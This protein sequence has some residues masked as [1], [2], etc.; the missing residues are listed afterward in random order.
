[1]PDHPVPLRTWKIQDLLM[2]SGIEVEAIIPSHP[3]GKPTR[4]KKSIDVENERET[5]IGGRAIG[6]YDRSAH[7]LW[8]LDKQQGRANRK[9]VYQPVTPFFAVAFLMALACHGSL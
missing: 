7:L 9:H 4:S 6:A 8:G 5:F 3:R 2:R 1:M